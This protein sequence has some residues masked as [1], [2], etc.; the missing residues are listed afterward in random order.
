MSDRFL[1]YSGVMP[2]YSWDNVVCNNWDAITP[3]SSPSI[4]GTSM[5]ACL[6]IT[7]YD[8]KNRKG[9]M[10]H[11]GGYKKY[12]ISP[13]EMWPENV[14]DTMLG[15]FDSNASLESTVSGENDVKEKSSRFP[16]LLG[17]LHQYGIPIL[18]TD[19]GIIEELGRCAFLHCD[20]GL[21]EIYRTG[22]A[23]EELRRAL[24]IELPSVDRRTEAIIL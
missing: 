15:H 24:G 7:L 3:A 16:I 23:D 2:P 11:L 17:K 10:A 5:T 9:V 6:V 14:I 4:I 19:V 22:K 20:S 13:R 8:L 21:V 1:V 12:I 18:G